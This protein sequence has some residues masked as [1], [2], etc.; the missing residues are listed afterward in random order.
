ME[1]KSR[2]RHIV[3]AITWR[4]LA[5]ATTFG[6][7]M[8]F[9]QDDPNATEKA[10]Y[11]AL[12]EGM[13]KL[14]L[15]YYHERFWF[16]FET[17]DAKK[18]HIVKSITWRAIASLTTFVV[19]LLIFNEDPNAAQKASA[20]AFVEIFAKM[21]IYYIHEEVWY[22]SNFGLIEEKRHSSHGDEES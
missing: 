18:R 11:V 10:T 17:M 7:A 12:I 4:L 8:I 16:K 19:A 21:I 13:I 5:S 15:Y 1:K 2:I 3:K 22:R 20:I 6:L 14:A 9:F